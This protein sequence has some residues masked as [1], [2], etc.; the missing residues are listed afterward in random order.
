MVGTAGDP[1]SLVPSVR[2]IIRELD[3]NIPVADVQTLGDFF[4]ISLYPFRALAVVMGGCGLMAL[5]LAVLGIY[6]VVSYSVAQRTR[7]L[8][9]RM[10]LGALQKDILR[11]VIAQGMVLVI[12]GLGIGLLLSLV[13]DAGVDEFVS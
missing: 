8:G 3:P 13:Y 12:V 10:A 6:G 4:S 5:L 2:N 11:L 1:Q 9:I 7:E